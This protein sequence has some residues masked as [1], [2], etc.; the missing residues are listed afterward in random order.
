MS[1]KKQVPGVGHYKPNINSLLGHSFQVAFP[2][3]IMPEVERAK[4][5]KAMKAAV[6]INFSKK[7]E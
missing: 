4:Q 7:L 5:L 6:P 2:E 3:E 1:E